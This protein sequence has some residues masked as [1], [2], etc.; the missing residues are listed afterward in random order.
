MPVSIFVMK[1]VENAFKSIH[2]LHQSPPSLLDDQNLA[3]SLSELQAKYQVISG[4]PLDPLL[5]QISHANSAP[6]EHHVTPLPKN[7]AQPI[8]HAFYDISRD[9]R[10][11]RTKERFTK[12]DTIIAQDSFTPS[13]EIAKVDN[14]EMNVL[15]AKGFINGRTY[16]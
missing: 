2:D 12:N 1:K 6:E 5:T 7:V 16:L 8:S 4:A 9:P 11:I 13:H 3:L 15:S 10:H 14:S